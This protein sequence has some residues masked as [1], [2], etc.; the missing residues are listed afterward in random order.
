MLLDVGEGIDD[1]LVH[2]DS[3]G[4]PRE[5]ERE[6]VALTLGTSPCAVDEGCPYAVNGND[7]EQIVDGLGLAAR[8]EGESGTG[9]EDRVG[10]RTVKVVALGTEDFEA[11]EGNG[12]R[13]DLAFSLKVVVEGEGY[14]FVVE[15]GLVDS[16]K[17]DAALTRI[18]VILYSSQLCCI[19]NGM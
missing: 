15:F 14:Y 17:E 2:G 16:T 4:L 7:T 18:E 1:H 19:N 6:L 11:L 13:C 10:D 12:K 5:L 3:D 8:E 9:V